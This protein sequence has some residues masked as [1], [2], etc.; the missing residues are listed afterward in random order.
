MAS[1]YVV[2][3]DIH[4]AMEILTTADSSGFLRACLI[5]DDYVHQ[6]RVS[7]TYEYE[8]KYLNI[9]TT[10]VGFG[11]KRRPY[12]RQA[13]ELRFEAEHAIAGEWQRN[14]KTLQIQI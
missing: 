11:V 12:N 5:E 4:I 9:S 3:G 14:C 7:G 10:R 2:G 8:V 1:G 13:G 6:E